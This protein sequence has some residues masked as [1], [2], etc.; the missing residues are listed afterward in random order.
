MKITLRID[1]KDKEFL[2]DFVTARNYR[3]ALE[4]HRNLEA[5]PQIKDEELL[6]DVLPFI[7]SVF[8]GQFTLDDLWDGI[9]FDNISSEAQ[10]IFHTVLGIFKE[11]NE[12][13]DETGNEAGK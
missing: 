2:N 3:K 9:R 7:V 8:A 5:N 4:I 1:G 12:N 10:R 11:E 6:E 13:E